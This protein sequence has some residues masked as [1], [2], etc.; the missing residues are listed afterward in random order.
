MVEI[1][2]AFNEL[3]SKRNRVLTGVTGEYYV[4]A[5]LSRRG[6]LASHLEIPKVLMC[7]AP[8]LTRASQLVFKSKP[9][10]E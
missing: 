9:R 5:E 8:T 4:A 6:Y 3:E 1:V 7:F 10:R 2:T